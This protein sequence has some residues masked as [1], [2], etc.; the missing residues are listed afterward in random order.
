MICFYCIFAIVMMRKLTTVFAAALVLL[1]LPATVSAQSIRGDSISDN[2]MYFRLFMPMVLYRSAVSEAITP[3]QTNE[4]DNDSLLPIKPL[5]MG[6]DNTLAKMIDETLMKQ[7]AGSTSD[8]RYFRATNKKAL[9]DIFSQI[10]EMEKSKID[11]TQ[12]AQT[13]DEQGRW[14]W[15]AIIALLLELLVRWGWMKW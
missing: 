8:G 11:V 1:T 14:L 5:D 10:D 3:E 7:M 15:I 12:Y 9:Q 6:Y 4:V 13:K 2:P